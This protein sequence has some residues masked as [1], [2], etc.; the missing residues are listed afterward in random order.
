MYND[1][2]VFEENLRLF[3]LLC[4]CFYIERY[5]IRVRKDCKLNLKINSAFK[6]LLKTCNN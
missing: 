2:H 5:K 4:T 6:D 3:V 1:N